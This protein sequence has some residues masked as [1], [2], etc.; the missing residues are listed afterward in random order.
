MKRLRF[1]LVF[2]VLLHTTGPALFAAGH[3]HKHGKPPHFH[4]VL[5]GTSGALSLVSGTTSLVVTGAYNYLVSPGI[6]IGLRPTFSYLEAGNTS[7]TTIILLGGVTLNFPFYA[8]LQR[9]FFIFGGA[10]FSHTSVIISSTDF[11]FQINVG[12]RWEIVEHFTFRPTVGFSK[13][14]SAN[15]VFNIVPLAFS[16]IF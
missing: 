15:V 3:H 14:G 13:T 7:I 1:A 5:F 6:Q 4:E 12:K 11:T 16:V 8:N 9:A 2:T 10:G